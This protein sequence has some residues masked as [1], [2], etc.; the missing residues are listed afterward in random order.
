MVQWV[1]V[2]ALQQVE[3]EAN[4]QQMQKSEQPQSTQVAADSEAAGEATDLA[5]SKSGQLSVRP[6]HCS[7]F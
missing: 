4:G 5:S 1:L 2:Q 3:A 7:F 6:K